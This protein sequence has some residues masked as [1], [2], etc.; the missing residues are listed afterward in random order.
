MD[1]ITYVSGDAFV[2][3][4]TEAIKREFKRSSPVPRDWVMGFTGADKPQKPYKRRLR[5]GTF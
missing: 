4:Q 1:K 3:S 2:A 5:V